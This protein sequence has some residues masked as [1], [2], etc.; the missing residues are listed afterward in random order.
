[1][2]VGEQTKSCLRTSNGDVYV[3]L[4]VCHKVI[5]AWVHVLFSFLY[6]IIS[7]SLSELTVP[8]DTEVLDKRLPESSFD[9]PILRLSRPAT[10][11]DGSVPAPT[12]QK[13]VALI[14]ALAPPNNKWVCRFMCPHRVFPITEA[15]LHLIFDIHNMNNSIIGY[16]KFDY[17]NLTYPS[18]FRILDFIFY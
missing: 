13:I 4:Y 14:S 8:Y 18:T 16:V 12:T 10:S 3:T 7:V 15:S 6:A 11:S 2:F 17:S 5:H 9:R 1:M